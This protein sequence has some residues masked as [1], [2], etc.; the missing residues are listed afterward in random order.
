MLTRIIVATL[1]VVS[2]GQALEPLS[3]GDK[4]RRHAKGTLGPVGILS[5]AARAG[6]DQR[7]DFPEEWG[8]GA[9][10]YGKRFASKMGK[11]GIHSALAFG[12]DSALHQDPRYYRSD[13][14][15]FWGRTGHALRGTI[16]THT[17]SGGETFSTWRIGSAYGAAFLANQWHPDRLNTLGRGLRQGSISLGFDVAKNMGAEFW[18]DIKRKMFGKK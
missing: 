9:D 10:A 16:L 6:I 3:V 12:L 8:Q 13:G 11:S 14:G 1:A 17:D 7:S 5:A 4:F 18:P 2:V 15:G